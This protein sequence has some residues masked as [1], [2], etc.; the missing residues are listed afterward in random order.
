MFRV[1]IFVGL[2]LREIGYWLSM[3]LVVAL[4]MW[5]SISI[6]I[7][8]INKIDPTLPE[9]FATVVGISAL[10][11][12]IGWPIFL[13]WIFKDEIKNW[14]SNNWYEAGEIESR[15]KRRKEK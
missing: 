14:I 11:G 4:A 10:V 8:I 13:V 1:L 6:I 15:W 7:Y 9:P 2:K 12:A 3:V 5:F